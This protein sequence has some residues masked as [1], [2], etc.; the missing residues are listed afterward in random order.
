[1]IDN[2]IKENTGLN[3]IYSDILRRQTKVNLRDLQNFP[4][5]EIIQ[6]TKEDYESTIISRYF[7]KKASDPNYR[8]VEVGINQFNGFKNSTFFQILEL[9][10]KMEMSEMNWV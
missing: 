8:I 10:W 2:K 4:E 7:I 3:E 5:E 6:I 9:R 1:M